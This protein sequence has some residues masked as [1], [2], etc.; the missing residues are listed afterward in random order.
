MRD[1]TVQRCTEVC[2]IV[3]QSVHAAA[4][5]CACIETS[6]T[7]KQCAALCGIAHAA[8]H[9]VRRAHTRTLV[10]TLTETSAVGEQGVQ[11][12]QCVATQDRRWKEWKLQIQ[13]PTR[14]HSQKLDIMHNRQ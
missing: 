12:W 6:T 5:V 3:C 4:H 9:A 11:R 2:A 10:H 1:N 7:P 13:I 14:Q 8:A